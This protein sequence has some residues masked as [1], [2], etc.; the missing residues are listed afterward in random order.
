LGRLEDGD[1]APRPQPVE[2][3]G[4]CDDG[5][6]AK[7]DDDEQD[8]KPRGGEDAAPRLGE[9]MFVFVVVALRA[10]PRRLIERGRK[11]ALIL[12][13]TKTPTNQFW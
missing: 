11:T 3:V 12:S 6:D 5:G 4:E 8:P 1:E 9:L 2:G 13:R 7:H 10:H